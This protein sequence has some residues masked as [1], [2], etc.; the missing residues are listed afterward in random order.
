MGLLMISI[1]FGGLLGCLIWLGI[2]DRLPVHTD[3]R[4]VIDV[5]NLHCHLLLGLMI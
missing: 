1:V 3:L 4:G 5:R 2:G